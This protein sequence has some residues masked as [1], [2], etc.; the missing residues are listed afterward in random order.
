M[1]QIVLVLLMD[2]DGGPRVI[3]NVHFIEEP[4]DDFVKISVLLL[5]D[6]IEFSLQ[7]DLSPLLSHTYTESL[8]VFN[9]LCQREIERSIFM[10][11]VTH[12]RLEI[13][14]F[15]PQLAVRTPLTFPLEFLPVV[16]HLDEPD[17]FVL[18]ES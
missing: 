4:R 3:L 7:S 2:T 12:F 10:P 6:P 17:I 9:E 14:V 1:T 18:Q 15:V 8:E 13:S 5:H 16:P 11:V